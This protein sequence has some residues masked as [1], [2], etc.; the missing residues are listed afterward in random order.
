MGCISFIMCS[1]KHDRDAT[2]KADTFI[3]N[4]WLTVHLELYFCNKPTRCTIFSV[5]YVTTPLH[6]SGLFV[7]HHQ[8]A[9]RIM[10][11]WYLFY[12]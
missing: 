7:A 12:F 6:V 1:T 3:Y 2:P 11:Q 8:E 5:Y 4:V 9:E 10:W